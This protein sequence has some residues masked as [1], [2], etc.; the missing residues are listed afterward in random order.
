M[1]YRDSSDV[2]I[3]ITI[4]DFDNSKIKSLEQTKLLS[5]D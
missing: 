4:D 5:G 3:D 1:I 2:E